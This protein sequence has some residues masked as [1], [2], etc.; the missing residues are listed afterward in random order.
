MFSCNLWYQPLLFRQGGVMFI[1]KCSQGDE[2]DG[3]CIP[4]YIRISRN[5][6][7][8]ALICLL[9]Q[10]LKLKMRLMAVASRGFELSA[11]FSFF[12]VYG[13]LE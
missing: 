11:P 7:I 13:G 6:W 3:A 2:R 1:G 8:K 10:Y 4:T 5:S 12:K 9:I